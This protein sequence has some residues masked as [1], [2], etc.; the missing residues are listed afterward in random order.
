MG[1]NDSRL[2]GRA[3][4][5]LKELKEENEWLEGVRT[6]DKWA[7]LMRRLSEWQ[8]EYEEEHGIPEFED[9]SVWYL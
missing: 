8:R 9:Q 3:W 2:L 4:E 1:R 5:R 7:D 6:E